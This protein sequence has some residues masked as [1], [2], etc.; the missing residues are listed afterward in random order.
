MKLGTERRHTMKLTKLAALPAN[1]DS[2]S[3]SASPHAAASQVRGH[4]AVTRSGSLGPPGG[5]QP[6]LVKPTPTREPH[7]SLEKRSVLAD[8]WPSRPRRGTVANGSEQ[9]RHTG[10]AQ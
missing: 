8:C 5:N 3:A 6:N 1:P 2:E 4:A 9:N 10:E 7:H